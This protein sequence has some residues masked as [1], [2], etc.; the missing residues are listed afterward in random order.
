MKTLLILRHGKSSWK[1][2]VD[3]HERPL[4]KRGKRDAQRL[5][6][7]LR[8]RGVTPDLIV[9]STA[10]RARSTAKRV[11]KAMR[12]TGEFVHTAELYFTSYEEELAVVQGL[13][14]SVTTAMIVGHNPLFEELASRL[15]GQYVRMPT[16][17]LVCL[18]FETESWVKIGRA[19]ATLRFQLIPDKKGT[20]A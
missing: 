9:S 19:P 3:D 15:A 17:A 2:P 5:G 4:K 1:E 8:R 13:P 6:E 18:D 12:Y 14:D 7:T 11:A 10:K 20:A 16:A